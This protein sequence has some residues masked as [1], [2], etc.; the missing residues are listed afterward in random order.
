MPAVRPEHPGHHLVPPARIGRIH[1]DLGQARQLPGGVVPRR[2]RVDSQPVDRAQVVDALADPPRVPDRGRGMLVVRSVVERGEQ[3]RRLVDE[4]LGHQPGPGHQRVTRGLLFGG[5]AEPGQLILSRRAHVHH[6]LHVHQPLLGPGRAGE[7]L[8]VAAQA[9]GGVEHRTPVL[10]RPGRRVLQQGAA[11]SAPPL[12]RVHHQRQFGLVEVLQVGQLQPVPARDRAL[13][14]TLGQPYLARVAA[15][16]DGQP[17]AERPFGEPR[18][19][20]FV[21]LLGG[22]ER[23]ETGADRVRVRRVNLLDTH[24]HSKPGPAPSTPLNIRPALCCPARLRAPFKAPPSL[25]AP[26]SLLS[27]GGAGALWLA[28]GPAAP[29]PLARSGRVISMLRE[30]LLLSGRGGGR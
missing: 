9:R 29:R 26:S 25:V 4:L 18:P 27:P 10:G 28:G 1:R 17:A 6:P 22:Q 3:R 14:W 13:R 8:A 2:H 19:V 5:R 7:G 24:A 15:P 21:R 20:G 11:D 23:L 12:R 16:S 30:L